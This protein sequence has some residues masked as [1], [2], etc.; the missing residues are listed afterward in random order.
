MY[1]IAVIVATI[2]LLAVSG[3]AQ[4]SAAPPPSIAV[5]ANG[6]PVLADGTPI[7]LKINHSL[8]SSD[9][10]V[11]EGVDCEVT[12]E[13][14]V[15][16]IVVIQKGS[17]VI[18]KVSTAQPKKE[19]DHTGKLE[20]SAQYVRLADGNKAQVRGAERNGGPS[21]AVLNLGPRALPGK[22]IKLANGSEVTAYIDGNITIDPRRFAQ[23]GGATATIPAAIL[24]SETTELQISSQPV[25][26]EV[27]VDNTLVGETPVRVI[28]HNGDHVLAVRVSGY[29]G[30]FRTIHTS[31]GVMPVVATLETGENKEMEYKDGLSSQTG[32]CAAGVCGNSPGEAARAAKA[33]RAQQSANPS[34]DNAPRQ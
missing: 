28:V 27:M 16:N 15:G 32:A 4:D 8:A 3:C 2:S 18:A 31:G 26:A 17:A 10:K 12:E 34:S 21:A 13:V 22:D 19:G 24:A 5:A 9:A 25:T 30:W 7:K 20:V 1:R 11:G 29:T 33:R 23:L 6:L 14:H